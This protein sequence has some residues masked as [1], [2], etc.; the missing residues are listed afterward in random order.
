MVLVSRRL[1]MPPLHN[2]YAGSELAA[3]QCLVQQWDLR[4]L[5]E[6]QALPNLVAFDG[7]CYGR[8]VSLTPM[9][10]KMLM[11]FDNSARVLPRSS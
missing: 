3:L 6:K 11:V 5:H 8:M 1:R 10:T 9:T 2:A 7:D 4:R